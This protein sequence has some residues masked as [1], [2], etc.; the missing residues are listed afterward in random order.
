M[1]PLGDELEQRSVI[2]P[3]QLRLLRRFAR[4]LA[5]KIQRFRRNREGRECFR[6]LIEQPGIDRAGFGHAVCAFVMDER[7][8]EKLAHPAV[9]FSRAKVVVIQKNL[10]LGARFLVV[11]R[12]RDGNRRRSCSLRFRRRFRSER[13]RFFWNRFRCDRS[14]GQQQ[15]QNSGMHRRSNRLEWQR[16]QTRSQRFAPAGNITFSGSALSAASSFGIR[17]VLIAPASRGG[18]T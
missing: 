6:H 1:V 12:Q 5:D 16:N 3:L 13:R 4:R 8:P 9:D 2:Q 10:E 15:N 14:D 18:T 7:L 17:R 11:V